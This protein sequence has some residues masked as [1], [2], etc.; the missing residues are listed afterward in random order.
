MERN[1]TKA[2][3]FTRVFVIM[4]QYLSNIIIPDHVA[5][6]FVYPQANNAKYTITDKVIHHFL[7]GFVRW[8]AQYFMHIAR[9]GYTYE[10]SLPF[11]PL[12]P[13]VVRLIAVVIYSVFPVISLDSSLLLVFTVL[14]VILFVLSAKTLFKLTTLIFD[15]TM[16][17]RTALLF[18]INPATIFFSAPYAECMFC[19]L[20]L[21]TILNCVILYKKHAS[22][23]FE[24]EYHNVLYILPICLSAVVRSNG[25]L[26][27]GFLIYTYICIYIKHWP[28]NSLMKG[29]LF[30]L[31]VLWKIS[32]LTIICLAPFI[33][34]QVYCYDMFCTNFETEYPLNVVA[35]A[36]ENNYVLSGQFSKYNQSWCYDRI[37]LAY[38][39]VQSHYWN[40]GFLKY[41][42]LKE[43]PN[44]LLASPILIILFKKS[45][46]HI[47]YNANRNVID[48]FSFN[49]LFDKKKQLNIIFNP[50]LNVFVIHILFLSLF[51]ILFVHVQVSTRMLCSASPIFYWFCANF[52]NDI[53]LDNFSDI[54]YKKMSLKQYVVILYFLSYFVIG[55][56]LFCNFL[57]WT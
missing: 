9:Y 29:T 10:N 6:A 39:Y 56:I 47:V 50:V 53:K 43:I 23:N 44:F 5:D 36:Q 27:I 55:I 2:A 16:A 13:L 19:Y 4:L 51:C 41:Y 38:S 48:I 31:M 57:P 45:C 18:C 22:T 17:Y 11:F 21:Q 7:E 32:I 40:V 46:Q 15:E 52:F 12:Y 8:D 34:Y 24:L 26:N 28:K 49:K 37:P 54:F 20:T 42:Q 14:N 3:V 33:I 1:V 30:L 35:H 25:I